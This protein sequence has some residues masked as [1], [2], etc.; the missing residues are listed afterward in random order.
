MSNADVFISFALIHNANRRDAINLRHSSGGGDVH[1]AS[2]LIC[3]L[4]LLTLYG[5]QESHIY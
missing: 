1:Y 3:C 5:F 2:D 4:A